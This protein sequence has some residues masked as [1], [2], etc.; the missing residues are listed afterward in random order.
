MLYTSQMRAHLAEVL[1]HVSATG[2]PVIVRKKGSAEELARVVPPARAA[3]TFFGCMST[4]T[5]IV[6]SGE[7]LY[8][9]GESWETSAA[10]PLLGGR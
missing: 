2:R 5:T 9:A 3:A 8:S 6:G 4:Q 7:E 1:S 10:D